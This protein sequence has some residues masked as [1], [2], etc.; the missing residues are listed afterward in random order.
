MHRSWSSPPGPSSQPS[1]STGSLRQIPRTRSLPLTLG[2]S[3]QPLI[4]ARDEHLQRKFRVNNIPF[5]VQFEI[6]RLINSSND[7]QVPLRGLDFKQIADVVCK[8]TK[9]NTEGIDKLH[10]LIRDNPNL[11]S[12]VNGDSLQSNNKTQ[13]SAFDLEENVLA[14]DPQGCIGHFGLERLNVEDLKDAGEDLSCTYYYG[15]K[16]DFTAQLSK[17]QDGSYSVTLRKAKLTQ[18]NKLKRR[19]GSASVLKCKFPEKFKGAG[20]EIVDSFA[21]RPLVLWD[22][23][24]RAISAKDGSI[25][26][27]R[28]NETL[29]DD[30]KIKRNTDN[31]PNNISFRKLIEWA[32]P[33]AR[34]SGSNTVSK[35]ASRM[36]LVLSTSVPGPLLELDAITFAEDIKSE[37]GSDMT[38]GC[39]YANISFFKSVQARFALS[40]VPSA[41]QI[42]VFG[43]KG[44]LVRNSE[45]PD[46]GSPK[47]W[48]RASQ[49]KILLKKSQDDD[50]SHK[51]VDILRVARTRTPAR[52]STEV[53]INLSHNGVPDEIF[54]EILKANLKASLEPLMEW[55]Q[56]KPSD[57]MRLWHAVDKIDSVSS[58]RQAR[59]NPTELRIR[60]LDEDSRAK[61][62]EEEQPD[63]WLPDPFSGCPAFFSEIIEELLSAGFNPQGCGFLRAKLF[64]LLKDQIPRKCSKQNWDIEQSAISFAVPDPYGV[65]G[66]DE[67]YF[68]SSRNE[69]VGANGLLSSSMTGDVLITRNPCKLPTDVRKVKA[70]T[71]PRLD[72][73]VDCIVFPITGKRRLIDFLAGGDYDG[74][75]VTVIW[76]STIVDNFRNAPESFANEPLEVGKCFEGSKQTTLE[77]I[78]QLK[79]MDESSYISSMQQHLLSGLTD[80]YIIGQY[81]VRHDKLTYMY[82][83]DDS[84]AVREAYMFCTVLDASKSGKKLLKDVRDTDLSQKLG[85]LP[86]KVALECISPQTQTVSSEYQP[87]PHLIRQNKGRGRFIMDVLSDAA[88]KQHR[89]WMDHTNGFFNGVGPPTSPFEVGADLDLSA[90]WRTFHDAVHAGDSEDLRDDWTSIKKF[91]EDLRGE[92]CDRSEISRKCSKQFSSFPS[93][94][95]LRSFMDENTIARLLASYAYYSCMNYSDQPFPWS[96]AFRELCL[97]KAKASRSGFMTVVSEFA[98][99]Y[100]LAKSSR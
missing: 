14:I 2:Q 55:G 97:I 5:G 21:K 4:I 94:G 50:Q 52:L 3:P 22:W 26:F 38:D 67:I 57:M 36:T 45:A 25:F 75:R 95:N 77:Y 35:W 32:N 71:H 20:N 78:R 28:T 48:L 40:E 44:M 56:G 73:L 6:A 98:D 92:F 19:F 24:Y 31:R 39:G 43:A 96:M 34:A 46:V 86:W 49:R 8:S 16:V 27:F 12:L 80:P 70:V 88:V 7:V 37:D 42:R 85:Q 65:L 18:S 9:P 81:S 87:G 58:K 33:L 100:R 90:P 76:D 23:V 66:P 99:N 84:R 82:G 68:K 51:T 72:S 53:I 1:S 10:S 62:D 11:T 29:G 69:F 47:I 93:P 89:E 59:Q 30:G 79:Q 74:D 63:S 17:R 60:G 15:G 41:V 83:L 64:G 13:W 54:K 91:V 61:G